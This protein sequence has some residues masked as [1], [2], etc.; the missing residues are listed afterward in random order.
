M[1]DDEP[2]PLALHDLREGDRR[3]HDLL[4]QVLAELRSV[5]DPDRARLDAVLSA[6]A[7]IVGPE[8]VSLASIYA[9]AEKAGH[10]GEPLRRALDGTS[11]RALGKLFAKAAAGGPYV[12]R[13]GDTREGTTWRIVGCD[14]AA[15]KS[16][17]PKRE[18]LGE[19]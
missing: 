13:D 19:W 7:A 14:F 9:F 4:A 10:A 18:K 16:Q 1:R 12:V 2:D 6:I 17:A 8:G 15:L 11:P 3:T 5:R